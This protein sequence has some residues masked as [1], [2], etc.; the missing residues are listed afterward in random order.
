MRAAKM[1]NNYEARSMSGGRRGRNRGVGA[2]EP[3]APVLWPHSVTKPLAYQ[4]AAF[5]LLV[6]LGCRLPGGWM[7]SADGLAIPPLPVGADLENVVHHRRNKL[8]EEFRNDPTFAPN[9][10]ITALLADERL[11]GLEG[12]EGPVRPPFTIGLAATLGGTAGASGRSPPPSAQASW[13]LRHA[14]SRRQE[15]LCTDK[16]GIDIV[17]KVC[18]LAPSFAGMSFSVPAVEV[19]QEAAPGSAPGV[20]V[21]VNQEAPSPEVK[22]E[23]PE[24]K[25][26]VRTSH[27]HLPM[28]SPQPAAL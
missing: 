21:E 18:D 6:P 20:K 25:V 4:V 14:T 7:I 19:K 23:V 10:D 5:N 11:V 15:H 24:V 22:V 2:D 13:C 3:S 8:S 26:E 17:L 28:T 27:L 9:S 1:V 12:F 16:G